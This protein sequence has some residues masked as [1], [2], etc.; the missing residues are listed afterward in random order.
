MY[1]RRSPIRALV[2]RTAGVLAMA[3]GSSGCRSEA[4]PP[5]AV[6]T[7]EV[8]CDRCREKVARQD[9][10]ARISPEGMDVYVCRACVADP[11]RGKSAA[12]PARGRSPNP[13]RGRT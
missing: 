11:R 7:A 13:P 9:A 10:E 5:A 6:E 12:R 1:G 4:P 3:L 8:Y 2:L